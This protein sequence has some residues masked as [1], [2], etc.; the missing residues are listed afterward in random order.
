[1]MLDIFYQPLMSKKILASALI[2][3]PAVLLASCGNNKQ[4]IAPTSEEKKVET[5]SIENK[6]KEPTTQT[7]ISNSG[8]IN[9][10]ENKS[11]VNNNSSSTSTGSSI[12][13]A[14]SS[15]TKEVHY[16]SPAGDESVE[17]TLTTSG[18]TVTAVSTK[19]L[20]SNPISRNLQTKFSEAISKEV[21][22]KKKSELQLHAVGGAS[23][24]TNAF[25][26]FVAQ[27]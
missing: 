5:T 13:V 14:G 22:G 11:E 23:L 16:N 18:D 26:Q 9:S 8:N 20:A 4:T 19:P 24:T 21:V 7:E 10:E 6:S 15:I 1:M 27:N 25:Q 3:T 17:F 2:L 12:I